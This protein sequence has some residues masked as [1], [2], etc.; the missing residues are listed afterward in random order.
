[1]RKLTPI[2]A[3]VVGVALVVVIAAVYM[4]G[5]EPAAPAAGPEAETAAQ[6]LAAA[7]PGGDEMVLGDAGAPI[8]IIEYASLTC[9]HCARFHADT[10]PDLKAAYI[11]TG[12]ARLVYRDFPLGELAT[13]AAMLAHCAGKDRYF[14]FLE[15][16]FRSQSTWATDEQPLQ[17]LARTSRMGG[18]GAK[19]FERCLADQAVAKTVLTRR[20]EGQRAFGIQ[21]TPTFIINGRKY[22]GA[23][24]FEEFDSIL[25][26]LL[27]D[28]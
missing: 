12:K 5:P 18:L 1:L 10:L 3:A 26:P 25:R 7:E 20:L 21:S 15:M 27:P 9:G 4:S 28:S 23:M 19:D 17:A 8:T 24:P 14:G 2:L 22:T 6:A 13:Q 16:L 11:E